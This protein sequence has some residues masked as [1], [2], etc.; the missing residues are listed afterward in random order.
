MQLQRAIHRVAAPGCNAGH[1]KNALLILC[2]GTAL[3][4]QTDKARITGTVVDTSGA[5]V[6]NVKITAVDVKSG[7]E[8]EVESSNQGLY[9]LVNLSPSTYNITAIKDGFAPAK[10]T[11]ITVSVGQERP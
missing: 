1:V 6:P 9:V 3:Y 2:L 10:Y 7:S 11:E 5:L 4:A 8:R